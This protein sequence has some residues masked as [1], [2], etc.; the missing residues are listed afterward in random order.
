MEAIPSFL[1]ACPSVCLSES[2]YER[3]DIENYTSLKVGISDPDSS[4]SKT[5][6]SYQFF[7]TFWKGP[8]YPLYKIWED[9]QTKAL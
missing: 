4:G 2:P 5:A 8:S 6:I 1:I 9:F 3:W 7:W